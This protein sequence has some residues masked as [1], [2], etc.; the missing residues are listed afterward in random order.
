MLHD[1]CS[2]VTGTVSVVINVQ[3][4]RAAPGSQVPGCHPGRGD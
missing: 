1:I 3:K 2:A 4:L